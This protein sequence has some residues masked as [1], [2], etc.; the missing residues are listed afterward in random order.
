MCWERVIVGIKQI[1]SPSLV[2]QAPTLIC[3]LIWVQC[4]CHMVAQFSNF[5]FVILSC[6]AL[7]NRFECGVYGNLCYSALIIPCFPW[8]CT[9]NSDKYALCS[10]RQVGLAQEPPAVYSIA[11]AVKGYT[12]CPKGFFAQL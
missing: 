6:F 12:K 5:R 10:G 1:D 9:C 11:V 2:Y 3:F 8:Q 4:S 7:K